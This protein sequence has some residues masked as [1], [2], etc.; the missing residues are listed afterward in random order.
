MSALEDRPLPWLVIIGYEGRADV[1]VFTEEADAREFFDKASA[2]WSESY[3]CRGVIVPR[4]WK[5]T[6]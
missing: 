4:D 3:L 1:T 5:G 6:P 2:Q